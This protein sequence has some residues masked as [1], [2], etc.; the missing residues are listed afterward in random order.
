[1]A[2]HAVEEVMN[3]I[4]GEKIPEMISVQVDAKKRATSIT[5]KLMPLVAAA[6]KVHLGIVM[7]INAAPPF[8]M[9]LWFGNTIPLRNARRLHKR[10]F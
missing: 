9:S 7:V 3:V 6:T 4:L 1:M 8:Q 10:R 2:V 5:T